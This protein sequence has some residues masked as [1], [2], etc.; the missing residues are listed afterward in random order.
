MIMISIFTM[1]TG[2]CTGRCADNRLFL[3]GKSPKIDE[4]NLRNVVYFKDIDS[5]YGKS[6][7]I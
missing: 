3:N 7:F 1:A 4:V 6:P 2:D 5:H